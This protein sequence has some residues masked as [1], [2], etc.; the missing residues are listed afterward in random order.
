MGPA[1]WLLLV[2]ALLGG[3]AIVPARAQTGV[4]SGV[5][6]EH[7]S[8]APLART[9]IRL[10]RIDVTGRVQSASLIAGRSGQFTFTGLAPGLYALTAS[11]DGYAPVMFGQRRPQGAAPPFAVEKDSSLFAELRLRKMGV[12]TGR[13]LDENRIGI[14]RATVNAYSVRPPFRPVATGETDDRGVYRLHGLAPGR[15]RVRSVPFRHDD[16]LAVLPTFSPETISLRDSRIHAVRLDAE[17]PDAD[18][19]PIPGEL[20]SISGAVTCAVPY[21]GPIDVV[22][23]TDTGRRQ[24]RTACLGAY[25]FDNLAPGRYELFATSADGRL[26]AFDERSF[27]QNSTNAH[28]ALRPNQEV[29]LTFRDEQGRGSIA[30]AGTVLMRRVD[31]AGVAETRETPV[32]NSARLLMAPGWWEIAARLPLPNYVDRVHLDWYRNPTPRPSAHPDWHEVQIEHHGGTANVIL[33]VA[34]KAGAVTGRVLNEDKPVPGI[35]VFLW[36]DQPEVRRRS[37]GPRALFTN[38]AGEVTFEGLAP[39]SYRLLA[40]FDFDEVDEEV[41]EAAQAKP[42]QV[43]ANG[44]TRAQLN[45]YTSAE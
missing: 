23:S 45:P 40:S 35:P 38:L 14:R 13:V 5:A 2:F 26:A 44:V 17:A 30:M 43:Q 39:G 33:A 10:D 15:Y 31:L 25:R 12:I 1:G 22:I 11:R 3:G 7:A 29:Q 19:T 34:A 32:N 6:L 27:G 37:G 16:G 36:P 4:V 42:V 9:R 18:V 20:I 41:L 8:G 28:V 21:A 24:A